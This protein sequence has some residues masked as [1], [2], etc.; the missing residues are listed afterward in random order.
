MNLTSKPGN[1]VAFQT[2]QASVT[3][4]IFLCVQPIPAINNQLLRKTQSTGVTSES[5]L[6]AGLF[7]RSCDVGLFDDY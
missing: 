1:R 7:A 2:D 5:C 4:Q 3:I 6:C